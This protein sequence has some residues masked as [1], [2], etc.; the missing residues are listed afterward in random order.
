MQRVGISKVGAAHKILIASEI[1]R[2]FDVAVAQDAKEKSAREDSS[3]KKSPSL[4]TEDQHLE[5]YRPLQQ[6]LYS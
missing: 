4:P 2:T 6:T 5:V 3:S 1:F